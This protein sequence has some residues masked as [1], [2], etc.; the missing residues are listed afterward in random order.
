MKLKCIITDDEPLAGEGLARHI[1]VVDY[2][3]LIGVVQNPV[4]LDQLMETEKPDLIFLDIEMPLMS[5]MELLHLKNALPMVILTTAYPN[6]ALE[7]FQFDVIDYLLKPITFNRFFKAVKKAREL[8]LLKN[9]KLPHTPITPPE[10]D[11]FFIKSEGKYEKIR[12][13]AINY[14]QSLQNYV[15]IHTD[16]GK[17]MTLMSLKSLEE[18]LDAEQ[19]L[20]VHKS[21]L[22]AIAKVTRFENSELKIGEDLIPISRMNKDFVM[23]KLLGERYLGR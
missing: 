17:F 11:Y 1:K 18:N 9:Q 12:T 5:G 19:F 16:R 6:Y 14:I 21:Y 23:E 2:L 20:R 13:D 7:A 10:P 8:Y 15:I 22:V 3:E 4:E